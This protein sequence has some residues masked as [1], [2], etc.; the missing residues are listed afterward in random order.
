M[1][2]SNA[3]ANSVMSPE[4][5]ETIDVDTLVD[6]R[7]SPGVLVLA[8]PMRVLHMNQRAA[9]LIA[10]LTAVQEGS[11]P[12]KMARGLL[13]PALH[14]VC[15]E[16]LEHL[17]ART[18][19]KD[20]ERFEVKRLIGFPT[21][22]VLVRGVGVPEAGRQDRTRVIL[23]LEEIGGRKEEL[24]Q[25]A[26]QRYGLTQ[27]ERS[28]VTCLLKGW[29]NKEIGSALKLALP[30]VKEHIRHIMEKTRT[31]TRTGILVQLLHS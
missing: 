20:W 24:S 22:P 6:R 5:L 21:H 12:R 14:Q 27:R 25:D 11:G 4:L 1:R 3:I 15:A 26:T 16:V 10:K 23:L 29:T 8:V 19:T 31:T 17:K 9:E 18:H 28:V 2:A 13:P 30:T 7:L